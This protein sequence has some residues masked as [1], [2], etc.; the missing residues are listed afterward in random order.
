MSSK[1]PKTL[2]PFSSFQQGE[3]GKITEIEEATVFCLAEIERKKAKGFL[4]KHPPEKT[5]FISK[6]Y[7]PFWVMPCRDL[8]CVFDG[9]NLSSH[10]LTYLTF[11]DPEPFKS[12]IEDSSSTRHTFASFLSNNLNYF[13]KPEGE[14]TKDIEGLISDRDFLA[15]FIA[16]LKEAK[17]TESS[18]TGSVL[19]SPAYSETQMKSTMADLESFYD[20]LVKESKELSAIIKLVNQKSQHSL[21]CL[22][23]EI[24]SSEDEFSLQLDEAKKILEYKKAQINKEYSDKVVEVSNKF[25]DEI[26]A[27]RKEIIKLE[28]LKELIS[29]EIVK[30]ENEIKSSVV[31]KDE[32]AE[33]KWKEKRTE[34]KRDL[35]DIVGKIKTL[36]EQIQGIEENKKKELF[37][38]KEDA[39]VKVKEASSG[40][41]EIES[42]RDAETKI[43]QDEMEKIEEMASVIIGKIDNLAKMRDETIE[44]FDKV[45][46][47]KEQSS[48]LL[49]YLP[50]YLICYQQGSNRRYTY[51]APSIINSG[52]IGLRL[53]IMG[54]KR[55]TQLL[56]TRSQKI[57]SLLNRFITLLEENVAFSREISEAC[58]DANLLQT[59]KSLKEIKSGLDTLTLEDWLSESEFELFTQRLNQF[60][61]P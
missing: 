12:G 40:L 37:Q 61:N 52:G 57:I 34:L 38:L 60:T 58:V 53:K 35:P 10:K 26:V 43:C 30:V 50:F 49:V 21:S 47:K 31:N 2:L 1:K 20:Q 15:E 17:T 29:A 25:E 46:V 18:V 11:P 48:P 24:K 16:Y 23:K 3:N 14:Q 4:R 45:G 19:V 36:E 39:D 9:L 32:A 13:E 28:K 56:Q 41:M 54:K 42:S 8:T 5:V 55:I 33:Q 44:G 6:V 59:K 22:K 7:Y 27:I 51:V